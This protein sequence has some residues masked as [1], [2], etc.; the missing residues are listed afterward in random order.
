[1]RDIENVIMERQEM[2]DNERAFTLFPK[3]P[4]ELRLKIWSHVET[5]YHKARIHT[6]SGFTHETL[7]TKPEVRYARHLSFDGPLPG[8]VPRD[9]PRV[10]D[11]RLAFK[12]A[13]LSP[14]AI[15]PVLH[16]CHE[17]RQAVIKTFGLTFAFGTYVDFEKDVIFFDQ[18]LT[19]DVF[20]ETWYPGKLAL[21]ELLLHTE[22]KGKVKR[23][24]LKTESRRR[25]IIEAQEIIIEAAEDLE[26][27]FVVYVD[28]RS[29][30][31]RFSSRIVWFM[32]CDQYF[33]M[34]DKIWKDIENP[35][36]RKLA[37]ANARR[38]ECGE[39][40]IKLPLFRHVV[41]DEVDR[42]KRASFIRREG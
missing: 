5:P 27:L 15:H 34:K 22:L 10:D 13:F 19:I 35:Y 26:E 20:D 1:M 29:I 8:I 2:G 42:T 4:I 31:S 24:A 40:A 9:W 3:L 6:I 37:E 21:Q 33:N 28:L 17:S 23:L 18:S 12:L 39:V 36:I 32:A 25:W 14:H 16:T 30:Q 41:V 38:Q 7:K 11:V